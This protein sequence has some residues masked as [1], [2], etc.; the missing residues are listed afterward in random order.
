MNN[1][2]VTFPALF[3]ILFLVLIACGNNGEQW[4]EQHGYG[5]VTEPI[6]LG[7][8]DENL[9]LEGKEIFRT[10]CE[11]CHA[12]SASIS[13][14]ALGRVA[15]RRSAEF[16]I[17]YTL[18]PAENRQ[19]HPIGRELSVDYPAV[20]ANTGI[21]RDQARAVYEYLRYYSEEGEL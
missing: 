5:P 1:C 18:K 2:N 7:E 15:D 17:N 3:L 8:T 20:M 12:M 10:Y 21:S 19:N 6:V 14:P 11:A 16:V 13:G 9:A 4:T